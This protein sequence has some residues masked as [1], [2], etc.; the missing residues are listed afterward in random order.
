[1]HLHKHTIVKKTHLRE[2]HPCM[3]LTSA[4][5]RFH[6]A[7]FERHHKDEGEST[8]ERSCLKPIMLTTGS[9]KYVC[10][11]CNIECSNTDEVNHT[12]GSTELL[13]HVLEII[14]MS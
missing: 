10:K 14:E 7:S 3:K 8:F 2:N 1:M 12:N 6:H 13:I 4:A 9:L 5:T 11:Y